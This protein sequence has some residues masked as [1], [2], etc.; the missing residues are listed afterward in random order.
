[1]KSL[2]RLVTLSAFVLTALCGYTSAGYLSFGIG[3]SGR[4]VHAFPGDSL[5]VSLPENPSTGYR[6]DLTATGIVDLVRSSYRPPDARLIGAP[7]TRTWHFVVQRTGEGEISAVYRRPWEP[8]ETAGDFVLHVIARAPGGTLPAV[9]NESYRRRFE[10]AVG[11]ISL[12]HF[13]TIPYPRF[14]VFTGSK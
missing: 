1:M 5:F 10:A 12:S 4:T 8:E 6:W 11:G 14:G 2:A 9:K 3:D 7:G 13:G